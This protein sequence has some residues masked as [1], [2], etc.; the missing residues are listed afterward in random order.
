[1]LDENESPWSR[2]VKESGALHRVLVAPVITCPEVG[3]NV[4]FVGHTLSTAAFMHP[5]DIDIIRGDNK[6]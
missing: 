6:L 1:M 2:A 5:F 4:G 3:E